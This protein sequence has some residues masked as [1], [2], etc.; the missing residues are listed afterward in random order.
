MKV[1]LILV[2][3][4]AAGSLVQIVF[5]AAVA[6]KGV[7]LARGL[8]EM[9]KRLREDLGPPL[10]DAS[11]IAANASILSEMATVQMSRVD[12][13]ISSAMEKVDEIRDTV[14]YEMERLATLAAVARSVGRGIATLRGRRPGSR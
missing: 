4:I 1:P 2:A 8:G 10:Q 14:A 11:R 5:V 12:A 3:I 9:K 13:T 6:W 7:A